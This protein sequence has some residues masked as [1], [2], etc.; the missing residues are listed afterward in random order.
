MFDG[1]TIL[2]VEDEPLLALDLA[3]AV[4]LLGG[5]VLGPV[6]SKLLAFDLIQGRLPDGAILDAKLLDGEVTPLALYLHER[7]VPFVVHTG[8]G[9]PPGLS[10]LADQTTVL[11]KPAGSALVASELSQRVAAR[12]QGQ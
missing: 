4:T 6:P 2:I 11:M 7:G 3:D 10:E 8:T 12:S 1:H 9:L 5:R